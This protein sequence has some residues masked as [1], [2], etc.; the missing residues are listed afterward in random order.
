MLPPSRPLL[1]GG[2]LR[3][4]ATVSVTAA[5]GV[6]GATSLALALVAEASRAGSWVAAVGL[7]SLGLVA[8]DEL[9]V[10]LER[11]VLVAAPGAR[12]PGAGWW[13]RW[14][15]GSTCAPP[16]RPRRAC[17]RPTPAGSWPGPASGARCWCSSGRAGPREADL[18]APGHR[19]PLGGA[20]RR[21]RPPAG[22]PGRASPA[23]AGARRPGPGGP[24]S[25]CPAPT[26]RWRCAAVR[27]R[28]RAD[29]RCR[30]RS[31][32]TR[33]RLSRWRAVRT[34]VVRCA[35]WP[36]VAAGGAARRAG[37]RR[38]R[39]PGGGHLAGGPGRGRRP[40]TSAGGRRRAAARRWWCSSTTPPATPGPSSRSS[41]PSTP[42]P[43]GSRSPG[44]ARWPSPPG[45]R[46]ASSAA[47]T[48][49]WPSALALV[50]DAVAGCAGGRVP[51]GS[52]VADGPF[53]A[54]L[55]AARRPGRPAVVAPGGTPAFLADRCPSAALERPELVDVLGR[56]GLRT[57]RRPGR[58]PGPDVLARFG[59]EGQ[60][61][62]RLAGGLDE[63]PPAT[64]PAA[65]RPHR[66]RGARPAGRHGGPGRLRGPGHGRGAAPPALGPGLGLHPG[67]DRRRDRARRAARAGVAG[68]GRAHRRRPS[69]TGCAGS[70]TAG[71]RARPAT[72][73]PPG[74]AGCGSRPTRSC[75]PAA[76]SSAS[77]A[78]TRPPPTGP[79]GPWP[80][81]RACSAS[82]R[83]PC[84]S[85]GGAAT[86][87]PRSRWSTRRPS[88]SP[89][90]G[91]A[92]TATAWS[93]P[94]PGPA[95]HAR[96]RPGC[97]ASPPPAELRRRRRRA[98]AGQRPRR[99]VR[100]R[101]RGCRWP[102]APGSDVR[103]VGRALA[104]RGALVGRRP[105]P[106]PGPPPA[107]HR[108]RPGPP[109]R[110][111]GRPLAASRPP[112]TEAQ[113]VRRPR[114]LAR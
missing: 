14:S 47:T 56:L 83:S 41:P 71:S 89:S 85:G 91:P 73:P 26:A 98:G 62:W 50:A 75:P 96:R 13:R 80:G 109:R 63:R 81:C 17:A 57:P 32:A 58:P 46:P 79:P 92:P 77:G 60:T 5:A 93:G 111:R 21:P 10:A 94:W 3:R 40:A 110:P 99:A 74:S 22:P 35:D 112:T 45:A 16:R 51:C 88:T 49:W 48:R 97:T 82:A 44:R 95:A 12:R 20:R 38:P 55:A 107:R 76:A 108:R 78:A 59:T 2:G 52:G 31:A 37:G 39:Q 36:I 90:S 114:R 113:A 6:G 29:R 101:R 24:T 86:R 100:R 72:G 70:S 66:Q 19:G 65:R 69:P 1:P 103:G 84:P 42:S 18:A 104:A 34:L 30:V 54:A 28:S 4:G 25:G 53:A 7:P 68:R 9:G 61:A 102:A 33:V 105:P 15:T 67:G 43:R 87:P 23:A 27:R 64:G 106:A 11:L 8:A